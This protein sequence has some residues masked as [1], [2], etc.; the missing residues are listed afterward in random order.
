MMLAPGARIE[1]PLSNQFFINFFNSGKSLFFVQTSEVVA[2]ECSVIV[3]QNGIHYHS[4]N[5]CVSINWA[6]IA[7]NKLPVGD[8]LIWKRP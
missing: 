3:K 4:A 6:E 5:Q 7:D 8:L 2:N 1:I